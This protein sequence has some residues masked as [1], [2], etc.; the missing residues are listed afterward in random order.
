MFNIKLENMKHD[1]TLE[2][3]E[4]VSASIGIA[5]YDPIIDD[6]FANVF[7]RADKLM[8]KIKKAMKAMRTD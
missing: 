7:K 6:S 1:D 3:W 5:L 4:K 2:P 8:Y